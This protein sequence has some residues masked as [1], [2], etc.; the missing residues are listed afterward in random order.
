MRCFHRKKGAPNDSS[1]TVVPF[2]LEDLVR[3]VTTGRPTF[4]EGSG[5]VRRQYCMFLSKE[6][7][8][9][10]HTI[11][12]RQTSHPSPRKASTVNIST[13]LKRRRGEILDDS[14]PP[15]IYPFSKSGIYPQ[16]L[17]KE[18]RALSRASSRGVRGLRRGKAEGIA[19]GRLLPMRAKRSSEE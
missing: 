9:E 1:P 4:S 19:E 14:S 2:F 8:E 10:G 3:L 7:G 18:R 16:L 12:H 6:G 17:S 5:S 11:C 15:A 13:H